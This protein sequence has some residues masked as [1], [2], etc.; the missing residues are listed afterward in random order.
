MT[1]ARLMT[2]ALACVALPWS[3][4]ADEP[5]GPALPTLPADP[6]AWVNSRPLSLEDL[7]GKGIVFLFFEEDCPRCRDGWPQRIA[8][9]Q[10]A[11]GQP[12]IVIG[13]ISGIPRR[14][15]ENYARSNNLSW[16]LIVDADRSVEAQF[17]L[18]APIS[19]QNIMQAKVV[20]GDGTIRGGNAFQFA[21]IV[22]AAKE[23]AAWKISPEEIPDEL[24]AAWTE[25]ELGDYLRALPLLR[26]PLASKKD[27]VKAAAEKLQGV[28]L[29]DLEPLL[30]R[31]AEQAA[32][33]NAWEEY[34][35]VR[36]V[37]ERFRGYP[38][39]EEVTPRERELA[40][41]D[42]VKAQLAAYTR[43][44][45]AR[46]LGSR[47]DPASINRAVGLLKTLVE[48]SPDT[49]AAEEARGIIAQFEKPAT[50]Q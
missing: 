32:A 13:V 5:T 50:P 18:P 24:K 33:G 25:I 35:L 36:R 37:N 14:D 20:K 17:K 10:A 21:D 1:T 23:G 47:G 9:A 8:E 3:L 19:L 49:E 15:V 26:R 31:L 16:P 39:T 41:D 6:Q 2:L 12:V 30:A 11:Q 40:R 34:K 7:R 27:D 48:Q 22:A 43:L 45:A 44:N 42:N 4:R 38:G 29:T 28:V 46:T